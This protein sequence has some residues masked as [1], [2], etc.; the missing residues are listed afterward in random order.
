MDDLAKSLEIFS[1]TTIEAFYWWFSRQT[2][3]DNV[4]IKNFLQSFSYI[5]LTLKKILIIT[6][7]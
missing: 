2:R 4:D 1:A 6:L 5:S 3:N 7:Y